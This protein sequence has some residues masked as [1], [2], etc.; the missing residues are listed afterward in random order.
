MKTV[1]L[2]SYEKQ[3][4]DTRTADIQNQCTILCNQLSAVNYQQ[5]VISDII[6]SELTQLSNIYNGRVMVIDREY[7]IVQD[8]YDID[9]GKTIRRCHLMFSR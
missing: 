6:K 7:H 5:G 4:V 1:T 2:K 9:E 3:T 8:T